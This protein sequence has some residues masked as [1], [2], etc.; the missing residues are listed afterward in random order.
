MKH[1]ILYA[2]PKRIFTVK[3]AARYLTVSD[4]TVRRL[5]HEGVIEARILGYR[6]KIEAAEILRYIDSLQ[7]K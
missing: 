6:Y 2:E 3:E 7:I 1:A 4:S 5:I